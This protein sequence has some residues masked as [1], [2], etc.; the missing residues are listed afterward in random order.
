MR[1][2][3]T[4]VKTAVVLAGALSVGSYLAGYPPVHR[5]AVDAQQRAFSHFKDACEKDAKLR[6]KAGSEGKNVGDKWLSDRVVKDRAVL[7]CAESEFVAKSP[8]AKT[9]KRIFRR[10]V[11]VVAWP[12]EQA[13]KL[14]KTAKH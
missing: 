1:V 5:F 6:L 13:A 11:E 12:F 3:R 4:A 8:E 10:I 9:E 7:L 2:V 14:L